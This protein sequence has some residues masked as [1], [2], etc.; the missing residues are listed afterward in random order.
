MAQD[1]Q[2][3]LERAR[4]SLEKNKLRDAIT[5]YQAVLELAPDNLEALQSLGT[6]HIRQN[7]PERAAHYFGQQFEACLLYTSRCV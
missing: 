3:R 4:R 5:D 1:L 6:V 2:K 7:D